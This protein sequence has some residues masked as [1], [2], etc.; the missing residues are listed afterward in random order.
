VREIADLFPNRRFL[1]YKL[2]ADIVRDRT[3]RP[4]SAADLLHLA[5]E[6]EQSDPS[7]ARQLVRSALDT[8]PHNLEALAA[9][10][11]LSETLGDQAAAGDARKLAAHLLLENGQTEE[12]LVELEHAKRLT[13]SDPSVCERTLA[14]AITQG[15]R[16]DALRDGLKLVELYRAPGLHQRACDVLTKLLRVEPDDLDL[17][18]EYARSRVDCGQSHEAV[19]HLA[20]RGK[21]LIGRQ[22]YGPARTMYEEILD[23]EPGNREASVSIEMIDKEIFIRRRERKRQLMRLCLTAFIVGVLGAVAGLELVARRSYL[24]THSLISRERMI[25]K[26]QYQDAMVLWQGMRERY[27]YSLTS[28]IDVPRH[29]GDLQQ[30]LQETTMIDLDAGK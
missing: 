4:A 8:E 23:I 5:H 14:I 21:Q 28:W 13:P 12:A 27:P 16:E 10:A 24:E 1:A 20:R 11:R 26:G 22:Q 3:A 17:H 2:L 18:V 15:R 19:K 25:E 7:R 6:A 30:R 9:E 29:I